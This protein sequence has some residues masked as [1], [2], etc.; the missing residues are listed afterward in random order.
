MRAADG[1]GRDENVARPGTGGSRQRQA[2]GGWDALASDA[3]RKETAAWAGG[4]QAPTSAMASTIAHP[5]LTPARRL[6][7]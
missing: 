3:D 2:G 1:H 6:I 7:A 5:P 4:A